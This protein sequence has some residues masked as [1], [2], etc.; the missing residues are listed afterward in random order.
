MARLPFSG[1]A[2]PLVEKHRLD[3]WILHVDALTQLETERHAVLHGRPLFHRL[4]PALQVRK[5]L[6]VLA[7]PLP[8]V[9]PS[10][11]CHIGDRIF[12][13]KEWPVAEARI[14]YTV[15]SMNLVIV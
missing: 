12:S 6:D 9:G 3:L 5:F 2:C 14:H 1:H 7:L 13:G 4:K 8:E 11:A 10:D 15:K